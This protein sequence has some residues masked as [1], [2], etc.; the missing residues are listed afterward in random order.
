MSLVVFS[1]GQPTNDCRL[2]VPGNKGI[3]PKLRRNT[4][5]SGLIQGIRDQSEKYSYKTPG[6]KGI[7]SRELGNKQKLKR[8][9]GTSGLIQGIRDQS[10]NIATKLRGTRGFSQGNWGTSRNL[11]G[12]MYPP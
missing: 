3:W 10:E 1:Y 5:A 9:T 11:K 6:S 8:N 4:G 12:S 2:G 7:F